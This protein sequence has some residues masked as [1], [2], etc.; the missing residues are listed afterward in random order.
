MYIRLDQPQNALR[1]YTDALTQFNEDTVLL[2]AQARVYEGIGDLSTAVGRYKVP[3][4][5][6]SAG[7]CIARS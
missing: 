2:A 3:T 5:H 1:V 4:L 7:N 6:V